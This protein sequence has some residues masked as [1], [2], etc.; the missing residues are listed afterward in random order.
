MIVPR[1]LEKTLERTAFLESELADVQYAAENAAKIREEQRQDRP[2]VAVEPLKVER[3][4][5]AHAHTVRQ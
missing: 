1:E 5:E 4:H 2:R 3:L